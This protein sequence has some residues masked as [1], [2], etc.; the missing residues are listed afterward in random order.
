[1][2]GE[3]GDPERGLRLVIDAEKG[4]CVICH[5]I[6]GDLVPKGAAG[7]IGPPL[8]GV[9]ARYSTDELRQRVVD[10]KK[11]NPDTIMPGYFVA[12][13]LYR[14]EIRYAGQPILNAQEIEDVVAYL[15]TLR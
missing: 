6:P 10:P 4:N 5:A 1:M 3:K 8:E 11:F 7:D 12:Q 14:V 13:G 15:Q 9:G 2:T